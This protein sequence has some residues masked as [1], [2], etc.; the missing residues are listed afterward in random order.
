[1]L[2]SFYSTDYPFSLLISMQKQIEN[3]KTGK[4]TYVSH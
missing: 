2:S 1:M 3:T 4:I